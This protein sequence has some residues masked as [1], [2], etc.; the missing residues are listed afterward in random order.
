MPRRVI[1]DLKP[2]AG[3]VVVTDVEKNADA[4]VDDVAAAKAEAQATT[5]SQE[6]PLGATHPERTP[7]MLKDLRKSKMF[8]SIMY[9]WA[10]IWRAAATRFARACAGEQQICSPAF[11]LALAC[12]APTSRCT[13]SLLRTLR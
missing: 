12:A 8:G 10:R 2:E 4:V 11:T 3:G 1:P 6:I 7:A 9:R 13:T 5:A